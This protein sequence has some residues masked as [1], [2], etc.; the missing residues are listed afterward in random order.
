MADELF[1]LFDPSQVQRPRRIL[2]YGVPKIGKTTWARSAP[3]VIEVPTEDANCKVSSGSFPISKTYGQFCSYLKKIRTADKIGNRVND[4]ETL[5]IDSLD[6]LEPLIWDEVCEEARETSIEKVGGG[7]GKGYQFAADKWRQLLAG[8]SKI[9]TGY[10]G[11]DLP[12][13][14]PK[15]IILIAH[16]RVAKHTEP[17]LDSYDKYV[18]PLQK[19]A[20]NIVREWCDE[21]LFCNYKIF[22]TE[23][24]AGF[25]KKETKAIG[26]GDRV[27][28]TTER[29]GFYAGNRLGLPHEL[30]LSWAEYAKYLL[31]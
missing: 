19:Q 2:L 13:G 29:P 23:K 31:Q 4:F 9:N 10:R 26:A 27:I 14:V 11:D 5:V 22:T 25:N 1:E 20:D 12:L 15:T 3:K 21:V 6:W 7:Y 24:D 18:T 8:L 17:G 28:Y 30:P 16:C